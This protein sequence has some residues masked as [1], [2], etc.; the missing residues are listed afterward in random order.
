M[1]E[2]LRALRRVVLD[3]H[4]QIALL[5]GPLVW[6]LLSV[7]LTAANRGVTWQ[8]VAMVVLVYPIL[9]ELAFRGLLQ[10]WLIEKPAFAKRIGPGISL[11]NVI[12][13]VVFALAH[14]FSQP[15]LW[16]AS[17]FI[18]SLLFGYFRDRYQLV[19]PSII[20]HCWYNAGFV[21]LFY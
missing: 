21:W 19:W 1:T 6:L 13:S 9:E 11:A 8:L 12:V 20:L 18:P 15:P 4:Y 17:V 7:W 10:A 5:L 3:R 2:L 16:A 14:L